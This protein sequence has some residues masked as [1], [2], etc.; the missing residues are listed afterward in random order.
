MNRYIASFLA[1]SALA[2]TGTTA[3]AQD[4]E[5]SENLTEEHRTPSESTTGYS[6]ISGSELS[7]YTGLKDKQAEG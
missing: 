2:F 6:A 7:S 1:A 4:A 5:R 3:M